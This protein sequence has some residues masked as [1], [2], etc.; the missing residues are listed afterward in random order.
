M[1]DIQKN[2]KNICIIF[3]LTFISASFSSWL[4]SYINFIQIYFL[5]IISIGLIFSFLTS[6][7]FVT[8]TAAIHSIDKEIQRKQE[9]SKLQDADVSFEA[10]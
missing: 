10:M 1:V 2:I 4:L 9:E 7:S 5:G 8:Y 3:L 6:A